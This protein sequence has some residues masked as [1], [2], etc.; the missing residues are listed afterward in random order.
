[1][2]ALDKYISFIFVTGITKAAHLGL[3]STFNSYS[4]IST[5]PRYGALCGFTQVEL[6]N[7]FPHHLRRTAKTLKLTEAE[8]LIKVEDYYN[9]FCFDGINRVYNP[10][11][12][13]RFF[14]VQEFKKYWFQTGTPSILTE[15]FK[16]KQLTLDDFREQTVSKDFAD[17][18]GDLIESNPLSFLYQTGYLS[19]RPGPSEDQFLLD[20]PNREVLEAMS[21]LLVVSFLGDSL[22]SDIYSEI[23]E[24]LTNRKASSLIEELNLFLSNLPYDDF[25][26]ARIKTNRRSNKSGLDYGEFLYRSSLFSIFYGAGLRVATEIHGSLGRKDLVVEMGKWAWVLE[27]KVRRKE[28]SE[29]DALKETREQIIKKR[30]AAAYRNPICL[31]LVINDEKRAITLWEY[32]GELKLETQARQN[33]SGELPG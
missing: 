3:L 5:D 25:N 32:F 22:S 12:T 14:D 23:K 33:D 20:Y 27:F 31:G 28:E 24:A 29:T 19:L 15:L 26:E 9:G 17:D 10:F 2:K 16:N 6:K 4:D 7:Y 11:S 8:L 21:N 1:M 30:Y 18:P 13:L